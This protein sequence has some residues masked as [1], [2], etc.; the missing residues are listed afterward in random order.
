[1]LLVDWEPSGT[2]AHKTPSRLEVVQQAVQ[3]R[4]H[5]SGGHIQKGGE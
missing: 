2:M 3:P 1:M 4:H 5:A